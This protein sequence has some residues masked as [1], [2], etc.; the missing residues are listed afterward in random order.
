MARIKLKFDKL[1]T[2]EGSYG[3]TYV[4]IVRVK[5][6]YHAWVGSNPDAVVIKGRPNFPTI[7]NEVRSQVNAD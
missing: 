6:R 5:T 4:K 2:W 1:D 3:D 7:F